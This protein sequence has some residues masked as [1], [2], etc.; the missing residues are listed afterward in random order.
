ML[1]LLR[2]K[3]KNEYFMLSEVISV[4]RL[5]GTELTVEDMTKPDRKVLIRL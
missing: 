5:F 3:V 2:I 1:Q 4:I